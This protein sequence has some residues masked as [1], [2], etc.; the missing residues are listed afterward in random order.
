MKTK[1]NFIV[2]LFSILVASNLFSQGK[3]SFFN[4]SWLKTTVSIELKIKDKYTAIGTGF[5]LS[6][7][8]NHVMLVTAKHVIYDEKDSISENLYYRLNEVDTSSNLYEANYPPKFNI[9]KGWLLS[10]HYD[11]A[12]RFVSF[13]TKSDFAFIDS[14]HFLNTTLLAPAANV[15][16]LG[17]PLGLRSENYSTPMPQADGI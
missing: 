17:F 13:S 15:L 2:I 3:T 4:T 5:L 1:N 14:S 8:S 9:N 12:V 10:E 11:V 16:V 7:P 6:T